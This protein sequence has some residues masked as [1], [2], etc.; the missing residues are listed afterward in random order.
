M[1]SAQEIAEIILAISNPHEAYLKLVAL[2][3]TENLPLDE[4]EKILEQYTEKYSID[5]AEM[6]Y[7]PNGERVL[8]YDVYGSIIREAGYE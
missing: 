6:V 5:L 8:T 2:T 1:K 3:H 7:H 4:G